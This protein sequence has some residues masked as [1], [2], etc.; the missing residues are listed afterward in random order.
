[1][2]DQDYLVFSRHVLAYLVIQ[3][4]AAEG[5]VIGLVFKPDYEYDTLEQSLLS[6]GYIHLYV[7]AVIIEYWLYT[8]IR[9]PVVKR[10]QDLSDV[11]SDLNLN[12]TGV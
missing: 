12:T 9:K 1:M 3:K 7:G 11:F 5:D 4:Y 10:Q 8:Y 2:E 6:I